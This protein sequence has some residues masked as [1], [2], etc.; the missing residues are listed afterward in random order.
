M[1]E[2]ALLKVMTD[3]LDAID[4]R[5]VVCPVLLDL[6]ATFD[7]VN[8]SMV[9]NRLKYRFGV[10]GTVLNWLHNY[11]T[12]RSQK[13]EI[14]ADQ[15]HAQSDPITLSCSV[16]QGLVLDLFTLYIL[17]LGDICRKHNIEYH[18]YAD[19]QQE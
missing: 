18:G 14:T 5:K 11:L 6:R 17:P 7:T 16:P 4:N 3:F 8:H 2:T 1:T 13:M 10:N 19:D 9:L 12:D 15:G